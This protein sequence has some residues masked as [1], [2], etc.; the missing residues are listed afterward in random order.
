MPASEGPLVPHPSAAAL[1]DGVHR[2]LEREIVDGRLAPGAAL[3]EA[4]VAER[5]GVSRTPVR[6]ALR[7]LAESGLV[8][9]EAS[10]S[11]RVAP[12]DLDLLAETAVVFCAMAGLAARLAQPH[13][14]DVEVEWLASAERRAFG[15]A[16]EP[17]PVVDPLFGIGVLDVFVDL[18]DNAVLVASMARLRLQIRRAF[19]L[20]GPEVPRLLF[21]E[22]LGAIVAAARSRDPELLETTVRVHGEQFVLDVI[23]LARQD[24]RRDDGAR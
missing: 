7:R 6:E 12:L 10:R 2:Q 11:Y 16:A 18:C 4:E 13:L 24:A 1:S 17:Q 8:R 5:L 14:T 20:F 9:I 3:R 23:E 19:N 15:E 21:A 22:R